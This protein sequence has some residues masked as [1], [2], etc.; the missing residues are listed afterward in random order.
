MNKL[1]HEKIEQIRCDKEQL[2]AYD[3][4]ENTVV[5]AGPGSGKT[6]I[7]TLKIL[8]LLNDEITA[9][10]G[11]ACI[12]YSNESAKEFT[13][14]LLRLGYQRRANVVLDT[15]HSFCISEVIVPFSYLCADEIP[16]PINIISPKDKEELFNSV[17]DKLKINSSGLRLSDMDKE[18]NQAIGNASTVETP[19]YDI[20]LQ[21]AIEY[22]KELKACGKCDF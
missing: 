4:T 8:R 5:I 12:T 11:L 10:R 7:L 1:F 13:K 9:P 19:S 18:R 21:A 2:E 17:I 16:Q 22:E 3:S 20:A 15:I 6:T 14:R